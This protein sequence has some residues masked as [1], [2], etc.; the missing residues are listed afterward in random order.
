VKRENDDG[1]CLNCIDAHGLCTY[2][3]R[4]IADLAEVNWRK[5][6][7]SSSELLA[8]EEDADGVRA[9]QEN[10]KK[11]E[12]E[13]REYRR[14]LPAPAPIPRIASAMTGAFTGRNRR[15]KAA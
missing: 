14:S 11:Q 15:R 8:S 4:Q 3:A 13:S 6:Q 10:E 9:R 5:I 1:D 2:H 12:E 7:G